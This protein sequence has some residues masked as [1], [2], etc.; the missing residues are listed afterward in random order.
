MKC[1]DS[2]INKL[3]S[4]SVLTAGKAR[5]VEP[6]VECLVQLFI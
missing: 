4:E 6:E 1:T 5:H 2:A 3:F